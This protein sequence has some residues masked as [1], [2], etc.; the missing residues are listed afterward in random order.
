[1]VFHASFFSEESFVLIYLIAE[2]KKMCLFNLGLAQ[3]LQS[4]PN[5]EINLGDILWVLCP[6]KL[7]L[8]LCINKPSPVFS[9]HK[10]KTL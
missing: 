4:L 9:F 6:V 7:D 3:T 2:I 8:Y 10:R 5:S 1:M